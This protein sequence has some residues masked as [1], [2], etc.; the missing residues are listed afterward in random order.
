MTNNRTILSKFKNYSF[1][2]VIGTLFIFLLLLVLLVCK[3]TRYMAE[4]MFWLDEAA[5]FFSAIEPFWEIPKNAVLRFGYM[6]PPLFYWFGHFVAKIGTDPLILRSISFT[7]YVII[8]GFVL[9]ALRELQFSTRIFLCFVLIMSPFSWFATTEFRPYALA[10]VSILISSVLLYRVLRQPPGWKSAILYSLAVLALQYSLI[11]NCFVFGLQM[12][13]LGINIL[14][15]CYEKG[16][17]TTLMQYKTVIIVSV[18][19][20][21]EYALFLYLGMHISVSKKS[22]HGAAQFQSLNYIEHIWYNGIKLVGG[23]IIIYH[24]TISVVIVGI[25]FILGCIIG[26]RRHRWITLYLILLFGGQLLFS[27]FMTFSRIHWF[28]VKYLVA[29]YVAYFLICALGVEYSFQRMNRKITSFF[30]ICL[31]GTTIPFNIYKFAKSLNTPMINPSI[32]AV[33]SLRCNN[34]PTVVLC[35]PGFICMVPRYAYRN[36]PLIIFPDSSMDLNQVIRVAAKKKYC[37]ILKEF[38]PPSAH[39]GYKGKKYKIL[40]NLPDYTQK[41]Y[42][43]T[44]GRHVPDSVWLFTPEGENFNIKMD[45]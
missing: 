32:Q 6:Q 13:F 16:F 23:I 34:Y 17:K 11:L 44:P 39:P 40:S 10:A 14:Y 42:S 31:L 3:N 38:P 22:L 41:K 15:F 30:L 37:F 7:F 24:W 2:K 35:D 21:I 36:D 9:I 45:E 8:I 26:L 28:H 18:L 19:L 4:R 12:A 5:T 43:I 27:T 20:C 29:S 1:S 33:E 25:P